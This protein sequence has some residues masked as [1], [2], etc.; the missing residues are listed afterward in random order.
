MEWPRGWNGT[1]PVGRYWCS[2]L[3]V[4]FDYGIDTGSGWKSPLFRS[5]RTMRAGERYRRIADRQDPKLRRSLQAGDASWAL[6]TT[7]LRQSSLH[8]ETMSR[9]RNT[10]TG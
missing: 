4:F 3:V 5:M 9:G 8:Q 7:S 1:I 6:T 10:P 2:A